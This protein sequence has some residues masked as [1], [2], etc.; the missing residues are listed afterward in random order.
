MMVDRYFYCPFEPRPL[1][2][3]DLDDL[4]RDLGLSKKAPQLLASRLKERTLV[5]ANTS[6]SCN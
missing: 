1:D 5:T 4:I 3:D 6:I 2:Q